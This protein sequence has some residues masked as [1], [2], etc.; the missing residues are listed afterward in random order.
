VLDECPPAGAANDVHE[1]AI[2][3]TTAWARRCLQFDRPDGQALFG[4]VQGGANLGRRRRHLAELAPMS[5]DGYAL[6]GLS[7][8]ESAEAMYGVLDG[9]ADELPAEKPRYLMGV[10]T[11][12]DLARGVAAGI[13]MFDCVLP[14]RNAR[15]GSLF[16]STGRLV[17]SH[18][19]YR[20]D[21]SPVDTE[22]PC[23]T[24]Q[25]VSRSYLRHLYVAKEML[26]GR[27]ATLHNLTFYAG[28][29]RRLREQICSADAT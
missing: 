9:F 4:I 5:F 19:K 8:G 11:P 27:L 3:R 14:T 13:D 28:H 17:I 26:Y 22:C 16:T 6:G 7:V 18:A 15:N 1:R 24:C 23:E 25:T 2:A 10:G 20:A 21:T 12:D 29:M